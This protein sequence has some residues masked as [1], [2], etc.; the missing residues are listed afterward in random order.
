MSEL[1]NRTTSVASA[2]AAKDAGP[3]TTGST[4]FSA[5]IESI[6]SAIGEL[7]DSLPSVM[8]KAFNSA[9]SSDATNNALYDAIA[10]ATYDS[11]GA[12]YSD[13][14]L[15]PGPSSGGDKGD[16][17]GRGFSMS[18]LLSLDTM[19]DTDRLI[20]SISVA[21]DRSL[22][23]S[24][25]EQMAESIKSAVDSAGKTEDKA[26]APRAPEVVNGTGDQKSEEPAQSELESHR[27]IL[28]I[29]SLSSNIDRTAVSANSDDSAMEFYKRRI[30]LLSVDAE[31]AG[32]N[33]SERGVVRGPEPA[34]TPDLARIADEPKTSGANIDAIRPAVGDNVAASGKPSGTDEARKKMAADMMLAAIPGGM[35]VK[36][37]VGAGLAMNTAGNEA[38]SGLDASR[39]KT[40]DDLTLNFM[41]KTAPD[42]MTKGNAVFDK[43][44]K[45]ELGPG[46]A[47]GSA[48]S[49]LPANTSAAKTAGIAT[50]AAGSLGAIALAAMSGIEL[51]DAASGA[52]KTSREHIDANMKALD[53]KYNRGWNTKTIE[54][55]KKH[56]DAINS[57]SQA[58]AH[59]DMGTA[60]P[61][62]WALDQAGGI[63]SWIKTGEWKTTS[64]QMADDAT[65][66]ERDLAEQVRLSEAADREFLKIASSLGMN[67][68][69]RD[70]MIRLRDQF[71]RGELAPVLDS[72]AMAA[73]STTNEAR[74]PVNAGTGIMMNDD[75]ITAEEKAQ[76][77]KIYTFEGVR[78]ALLLPEVQAMFRNTA[79]SAG[80]SVEQQLMG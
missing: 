19:D 14:K 59:K 32:K 37:A 51:I 10:S 77:Y 31:N 17:T 69:D 46:M 64:E 80:A 45:G 43:I 79:K 61:F 38:P 33:L 9:I 60:I 34:R 70:A 23:S 18:D 44:L 55:H 68:N 41:S 1:F 52:R 75:I 40:M 53:E 13:G 11:M 21:F 50:V 35:G 71:D 24:K 56:A 72:P 26:T 29:S 25:F 39:K 78:D 47:G 66:K 67:K 7:K 8:E 73:G 2:T 3:A 36:A 49:A 42:F 27:K 6:G 54:L 30:E 4:D 74:N 20:N 22:E 48:I 5:A 76:M 58:Q 62:L 63:A 15:G 65:K 12:L 28:D 57:E 16:D